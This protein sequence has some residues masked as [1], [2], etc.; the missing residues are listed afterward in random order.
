MRMHMQMD[1]IALL[2][3]SLSPLDLCMCAHLSYTVYMCIHMMSQLHAVYPLHT[4]LAYSVYTHV[5]T[6]AIA[7]S[8]RL[9]L[10]T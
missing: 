6:R 3:G 2:G 5:Y 8:R 4:Y 1:G 7:A 9:T 10:H